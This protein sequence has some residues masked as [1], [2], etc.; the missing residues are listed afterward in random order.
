MELRQ[1]EYFVA[2]AEEAN[3]TRAAER[4][5]I[6]QSGVSAQIRQLEHDL[7][8][9]LIDRSGRSATLTGAGT[10]ALE[11]ARAT[12]GSVQAL[13]H[14]VDEVTGVI[15]GRLAVGMVNG[16]TVLPLFDALAAFHQAHPGIEI[17]LYEDNS[18]R[19]IGDVRS[20]AT[21]LALI[22]AAGAPPAG[23][24]ALSIVSE[25]LVAVVPVGHPLTRRR[26]VRLADVVGYPVV[27]MP[28]GT[29]IRT[30]FDRSCAA[31]GLTANIALQATAGDAVIDLAVR[32]LGVGVLSSSMVGDDDDHRRRA[33]AI[34]DIELPA[35]LALVWPPAPSPALAE[36]VRY[37]RRVF[38]APEPPRAPAGQPVR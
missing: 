2:V 20:G 22:G 26:E 36:L 16:C 21:D 18:D 24:G 15:R 27:C 33:L 38:A 34:S 30:V 19:L 10:A 17:A 8:A 5:H 7:G 32:G 9:T 4:V 35:V 1:L 29:G 12:L 28:P 14:A 3:F 13:R 23:L 37:C 6:S 31:K 11:H 25:G